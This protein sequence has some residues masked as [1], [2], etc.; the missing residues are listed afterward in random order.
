MPKFESFEYPNTV[1]VPEAQQPTRR[2]LRDV[3]NGEFEGYYVEFE[4]GGD[5]PRAICQVVQSACD[6]HILV[7][8]DGNRWYEAIELVDVTQNAARLDLEVTRIFKATI[9]LEETEV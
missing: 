5:K 7:A 9:T 1:V 2:T 8:P 6:T 3:L 4:R